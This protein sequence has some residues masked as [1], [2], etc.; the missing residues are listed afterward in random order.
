MTGKALDRARHWRSPEILNKDAF[1][2]TFDDRLS[3][4]VTGQ[5]AG[6]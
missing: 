6:S 4:F 1:I 5:I 3:L 2:E